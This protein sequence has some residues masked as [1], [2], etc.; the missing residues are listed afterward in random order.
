MV[1]LGVGKN[2]VQSIRHWC[3]AAKVIEEDSSR[4]NNR[5]HYLQ[6]TKLGR[7]IFV[8]D[9]WDRYLEDVGTLWLVHWLLTTNVER[10]TTWCFAFNYVHQP[11]FSRRS[12][13]H[14]ITALATR[15][16][17]V[18]FSEGTVQRD[19]DVFIRTYVGAPM[20][21]SGAVED[22]LECPLTELG[23]I[24]EQEQ[25][26]L[27]AFMR[28]PKESLPDAVLLYALQAYAERHHNQRSFTF[29]EL[30]YGPLSPGRVF[31]LDESSLAERL[32]RV[33]EL[34][35]GAWE[36]SE[37]AGY[38]QVTMGRSIDAFQALDVYY[39]GRR[40]VASGVTA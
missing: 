37:T 16:P 14:S 39:R 33:S 34:T 8:E 40:D 38:K 4:K 9:A 30:A 27:Y 7:R 13:A 22:T 1:V 11:D 32:D 21:A 2:M 15:I 23:L 35:G 3:L 17:N 24:F 12:L 25:S 29:D 19:I 20:H 36:F 26:D 5:G 31:K 18:R 6:P 10:A 28:G